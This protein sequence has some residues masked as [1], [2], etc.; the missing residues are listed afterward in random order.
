VSLM[1]DVRPNTVAVGPASSP[2]DEKKPYVPDK[3]LDLSFK[4]KE[5]LMLGAA[6][7]GTLA[8]ILWSHFL[9]KSAVA[10]K[11][12]SGAKPT[13][14]TQASGPGGGAGS[15]LPIVEMDRP[16]N[17]QGVDGGYAD[18]DTIDHTRKQEANIPEEQFEAKN[19]RDVK[20][21]EQSG[22]GTAD[23]YNTASQRSATDPVTAASSKS[24]HDDLDKASL[25]F[26][27]NAPQVSVGEGGEHGGGD[28]SDIGIGLAPGTRL[29][30]HLAAAVNTAVQT[31]VV[32]IVEY[33]Y[34]RDG[35][36]VVPA[37]SKVFGH[38]EAA[39]RSGYL[40]VRFDSLLLPDGE[41][42]NIQGT[43]TDLG[44]QPLRGRVQ[45]Q[46]TAK[47]ILV[48]SVTGIGE[49]A[50]TVVGA[51]SL[52]QPLSQGDL[53]R[54]RVSQNI[55]QASDDQITRLTLTE[56]I[57]VSL[58]ANMKIYI[59]LQKPAKTMAEGKIANRA[60]PAVQKSENVEQLRQLMQLQK[61]LSESTSQSAS[62]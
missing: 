17:T 35:E 6:I 27:R 55:G 43:A 36:I 47:K 20:E 10:N 33:N 51:S 13:A 28:K 44:L 42:V 14:Q 49:I 59:V 30:A 37:G 39:D 5:T 62:N 38:L 31:P 21:F 19:L 16:T 41:S 58:P 18:A 48:R 61:E 24:E 56:H 40:S 26:V 53:I 25:V 12:P 11:I 52:D 4:A 32:A 57:V 46:N 1:N 2:D 60:T 54:D 22:T 15:T 8:I 3:K 50:A 29:R 34:Q 7:V 23:S 9:P 45:G